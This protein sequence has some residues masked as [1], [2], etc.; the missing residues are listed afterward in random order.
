MEQ[1]RID[2][3][4]EVFLK[5]SE[6]TFKGLKKYG[7]EDA[8]IESF[9]SNKIIEPINYKTFQLVSV[10]KF[11]QYGVRLLLMGNKNKAVK[12][13]EMCYKLAPNCKNV[14]LQYMLL[15]IISK[16][17]KE[18]FE[19]Y[20]QLDLIPSDRSEKDNNLYLYLL[21]VVTSSMPQ[22]LKD[23]LKNMETEDIILSYTHG[24]KIEN[25]IRGAI[26]EHKFKYAYQLMVERNEKE[27]EYSVKYETIRIL[28][29]KAIT[30]DTKIKNRILYLVRNYKYQELVGFLTNLETQRPLSKME[31]AI[32]K[33]SQTIINLI[34]GAVIQNRR[35]VDINDIYEAIQL[36]NFKLALDLS[37]E[38]IEYAKID[39]YKNSMY[40]LLKKVNV[41]LE[42]QENVQINSGELMEQVD[43]QDE[44][45]KKELE[46]I[47]MLA[48]FISSQNMSLKIARQKYSFLPEQL[49]FI[50]L[51]YARDYYI[52]SNYELGDKLI[53]EVE[54][55]TNITSKVSKLLETIKRE[56]N[57]YKNLFDTNKR[58]LTK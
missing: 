35:D 53:K 5:E 2:L 34:D 12:C 18:V 4:Y 50:K 14:L 29:S 3:I 16:D 20:R 15:K 41:L 49:L 11:R 45:T 23:R 40:L 31:T 54:Y 57:N 39:R 30:A 33:L 38:L 28:T 17:Y 21:G 58:C 55:S 25:Q 7:L 36:N 44:I 1:A 32:F 47:E 48:Y 27:P 13:F 19:V 8:E 51:I 22:D 24:R 52:E 43:S 46:D 10:D 37:V 56:R 42:E 9:I 6:I 26:L